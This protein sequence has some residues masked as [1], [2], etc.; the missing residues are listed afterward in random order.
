MSAVVREPI[1]VREYPVAE[2]CKAR[3][4]SPGLPRLYG[5]WVV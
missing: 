5:G 1:G 4:V 3:R 2:D